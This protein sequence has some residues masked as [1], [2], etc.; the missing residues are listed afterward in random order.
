MLQAPLSAPLS[1]SSQVFNTIV[2]L[3]VM[4][5][6]MITGITDNSNIS[7]SRQ[8]LKWQMNRFHHRIPGLQ[9][10]RWFSVVRVLM[11]SL[12]VRWL[13][14]AMRPLGQGLR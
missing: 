11:R 6:T 2:M 14:D 13:W 4:V 10:S 3:M 1:S 5:T 9:A 12:V 8:F 7:L